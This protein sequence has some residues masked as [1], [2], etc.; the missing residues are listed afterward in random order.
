M[1]TI[2]TK[3]NQSE[4]RF[5]SVQDHPCWIFDQQVF[6]TKNKYTRKKSAT[7]QGTLFNLLKTVD[8][9]LALSILIKQ[10]QYCSL[11]VSHVMFCYVFKETETPLRLFSWKLDFHYLG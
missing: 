3:K 7:I 6:V 2:F 10:T 4:I 9:A 1:P 5:T 8:V 11:I